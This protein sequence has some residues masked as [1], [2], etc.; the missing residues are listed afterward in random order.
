M[1]NFILKNSF[2]VATNYPKNVL[3]SITLHT[4]RDAPV[5]KLVAPTLLLG[6]VEISILRLRQIKFHVRQAEHRIMISLLHHF[7]CIYLK[8][9]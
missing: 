9:Q 5:T 7:I 1:L 6:A 3:F 2:A 8:F 4:L